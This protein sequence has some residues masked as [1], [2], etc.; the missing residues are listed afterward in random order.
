MQYSEVS[1]RQQEEEE[2]LNKLGIKKIF[3]GWQLP[4]RLQVFGLVM[5]W[6]AHPV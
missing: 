5:S 6:P 3:S 4:L 2:K 1:P